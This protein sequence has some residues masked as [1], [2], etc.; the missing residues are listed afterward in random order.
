M[1]ILA[2]KEREMAFFQQREKSTNYMHCPKSS[3]TNYQYANAHVHVFV[4]TFLILMPKN[5][6]VVQI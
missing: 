6:V 4:F 5:K 3:H 1:K 2:T